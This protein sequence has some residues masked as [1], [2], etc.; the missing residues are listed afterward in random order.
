M[1]KAKLGETVVFE[2]LPYGKPFP[3]IKWMKDG[4]ELLPKDGIT[5]EA[6]EDGTQ[7]LTIPNIDVLSEGYYRCVAT[8]EHGT[9]STKA[10]LTLI[11]K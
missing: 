6:A 9:A 2:C 10:E 7:K 5:I 11:G 3:S 8:N 4:I 1:K